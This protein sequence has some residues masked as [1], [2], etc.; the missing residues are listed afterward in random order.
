MRIYINNLS[1][2]IS[3]LLFSFCF[4][5]SIHHSNSQTVSKFAGIYGIHGFSGD[6]GPA[7]AAEFYAPYQLATDLLGNV[8]VA[9]QN[10][11]CIRKINACGIISTF[12]GNNTGGYNGDG[13]PAT[14]A[15]L[16][17]PY[18]VAVDKERQLVYI[19]DVQNYRVRKVNAA[20]IIS[21]IAGNGTEGESGDGGPATAAQFGLM[22]MLAVD[23]SHNIY[24][25]DDIFGPTSG[26]RIRKIDTNGIITTFAGNG[27]TGFSGD[28]GLATAAQLNY[29]LG[30]TFDNSGNAFISDR[31]NNRIRKVN[32][33]GIITTIAGNGSPGF[34]GDG[35][36]A[37]SAEINGPWGICIDNSGNIFFSDHFN[38]RIREIDTNGIIT[39][40]AGNGAMVD[41]GDGGPAT[42]AAFYLPADV[43]RN[44]AGNIFVSSNQN[45]IVRVFGNIINHPPVF[46]SAGTSG[47]SLN[48][49]ENDIADSLSSLLSIRDSDAGQ[50]LT[51]VVSSPPVHGTCVAYYSATV[52]DTTYTPP[53]LYYVPDTGYSGNDSFK[54]SVSDCMGGVASVTIHVTIKPKPAAGIIT[55]KDTLCAG[56]TLLLTDT[57]SGLW[58]SSN[59]ALGTVSG[60]GLVT[61]IGP[62]S[63]T[64]I[65]TVTDTNGCTAVIRKPIVI[66]S[67]AVCMEAVAENTANRA[68]NEIAIV[69][70]PNSGQFII[71]FAQWL[72]GSKA[73]ITVTNL[74]GETIKELTVNEESIEISLNIPQG[75]YFVS[76]RSSSGLYYTR[77]IVK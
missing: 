75:I 51:W 74:M 29:P 4:L 24:V 7:N 3:A 1:S 39:T 16:N 23:P 30:I 26:Y 67:H 38:Y 44:A 48:A 57:V 59:T 71:S 40:I 37:T 72:P 77:L 22:K 56:K 73:L 20:G 31:N 50:T 19:T 32:T 68:D 17:A 46:T 13:I 14:A 2:R 76:V 35:G 52:I 36:A 42:A 49:C 5:I 9:D 27:T 64:I 8:Y 25:I 6:G 58:S 70:N 12:A 66:L 18:G 10:N 53:G 28:G 45:N 69:P 43:E 63:D 21:T 61:G 47:I 11:G 41:S 60:A 62:G 54:I 33:A 55:G 34:S 15:A 65:Y